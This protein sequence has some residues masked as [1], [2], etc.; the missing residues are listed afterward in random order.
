MALTKL[1]MESYRLY[2]NLIESIYK[3]LALPYVCYENDSFVEA[4][5][6]NKNKLSTDHK[7]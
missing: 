5:V 6:V 7:L 1:Q 4:N 2:R 3:T